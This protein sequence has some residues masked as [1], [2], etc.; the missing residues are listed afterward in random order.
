MNSNIRNNLKEY[1]FKSVY[2]KLLSLFLCIIFIPS[3]L[4]GT[5][6]YFEASNKFESEINKYNLYTLEYI[7]GEI[8]NIVENVNNLSAQYIMNG[9]VRYFSYEPFDSDRLALERI[10]KMIGNTCLSY[11][12]IDSMYIYYKPYNEI[13]SNNGVYDFKD[14]YDKDWAKE[15]DASKDKYVI[16]PTRNINYKMGSTVSNSNV[17]TY[18]VQF[19]MVSSDKTGAVVINISVDK[20]T[21]ILNSVKKDPESTIFIVNSEGKIILSDKSEYIYRNFADMT[22]SKH[23]QQQK[24]KLFVGQ[25]KGE[26]MVFSN[27]DSNSMG[28]R[29]TEITPF[30]SVKNNVAFIKNI[31][32][33]LIILSL[34]LLIAVFLITNKVYNPLTNLMD[35]VRKE[36]LS[37]PNSSGL[38]GAKNELDMLKLNVKD[39]SFSALQER[40]QNKALKS[41]V[42]HTRKVLSQNLFKDLVLLSGGETEWVIERL[43]ALDWN[44]KSYMVLLISIDDYLDFQNKFKKKDQSLWK[45]CV[46][47]IA[48]EIINVNYR[49]S[50]FEDSFS[51]WVVVLN[52][53]E[54]SENEAYEAARDISDKIREAVNTYVK[55]FTVTISIG[56]YSADISQLSEAFENATKVMQKKWL[57]G[58]DQ[59]FTYQNMKTEECDFYYNVEAEKNILYMLLYKND[60][61]E[62][63]KLLDSFIKEL[64]AKN[65]NIYDNVYHGILQLLL[66]V[67]RML[68]EKQMPL[69]E[70]FKADRNL[71]NYNIINDFRRQETLKD[72]E[73]W[74]KALFRKISDYLWEQRNDNSEDNISAV[75]DY[76]SNNY[77]MDVSLSVVAE[78]FGLSNYQLSKLFKKA[79]GENFIDYLSRIRIEKSKTLMLE[80]ERSIYEIAESV[81]YTNVQTFIRVFKKLEGTTPGQFK[82]DI[83]LIR[84]INKEE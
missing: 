81:G 35:I 61:Q 25:F 18:I 41:Q 26:K 23:V 44:L 3:I 70:I 55:A 69:E 51:Q 82:E 32:I 4:I 80:S 42:N 11:P 43:K 59:T 60:L 29:F 6:I 77:N 2:L 9:E 58:K 68:N 21:A 22:D 34:L 8:E 76:I 63:E 83:K 49:G 15:L 37:D 62:V 66:A 52:L 53:P 73:I 12:Y 65:K 13:I 75:L 64:L 79:T 47:N 56:S 28:W 16:L 24:D 74:L 57:K 39:I 54:C 84:N 30:Q 19:P 14:F 67:V 48:E 1:K 33:I 36:G 46:I 10:W 78:K 5:F 7:Q 27:V 45:Y 71:V 50:I 72:A 38:S 20:L 31:V 40:E 17:I